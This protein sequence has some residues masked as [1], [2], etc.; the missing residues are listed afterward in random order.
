ML[1]GYYHGYMF[2]ENASEI[3]QTKS[4]IWKQNTGTSAAPW[5]LMSQL[6]WFC[7]NKFQKLGKT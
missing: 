6:H 4:K 3:K 7:Q 5:K 2:D 1:Y